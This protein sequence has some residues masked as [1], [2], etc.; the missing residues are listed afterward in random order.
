MMQAHEPASDRGNDDS[1]PSIAEATAAYA[2]ARDWDDSVH[3]AWRAAV[4]A[5]RAADAARDTLAKAAARLREARD[6]VAT[7]Q[8][9]PPPQRGEGAHRARRWHEASGALRDAT[10]SYAS[11]NETV[12][13]A[14]RLERLRVMEF[15]HVR[16]DNPYVAALWRECI[17]LGANP[18]TVDNCRE[19]VVD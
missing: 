1:A 16:D 12:E 3:L 8:A 15:D 13:A 14:V 17:R 9:L 5:V 19:E 4:T 18:E 7:V 6:A 2:R 10:V 11:V